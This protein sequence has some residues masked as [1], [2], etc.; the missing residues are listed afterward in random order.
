MSS[1]SRSRPV[2]SATMTGGS[3]PV[4]LTPLRRRSTTPS[5]SSSFSICFSQMRSPPW[6]LK[7]RAI[8]RL[9]TLSVR[10]G[11]EGDE[12]LAGGEAGFG[13]GGFGLLGHSNS[14]RASRRRLRRVARKRARESGKLQGLRWVPR[15]EI[16]S[17]TLENALGVGDLSHEP[18]Q[19]R[20][21]AGRCRIR[22]CDAHDF[23]NARASMTRE[24]RSV[25]APASRVAGSVA[26]T[27]DQTE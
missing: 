6:M 22:C 24:S 13:F 4:L 11:D 25:S 8:S 9:P 26:G 1:P 14:F 3:C 5:V 12:V 18:P 17:V 10:V 7:A 16:A 15:R 21:R 2:T 27:P 20:D 23:R 19:A